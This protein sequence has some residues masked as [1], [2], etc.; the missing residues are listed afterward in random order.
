[1]LR[2][3]VL[4]LL[5]ALAFPGLATAHHCHDGALTADQTVHH[6]HMDHRK[7]PRPVAPP[8]A[9]FAI[10]ISS[11]C[12]GCAPQVALPQIVGLPVP[13]APAP[14]ETRTGFYPHPFAARVVTP[15]P[16]ALS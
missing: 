16:R 8:E 11:P 7:S 3:L 6:Q 14:T 5:L 13:V 4:L 15:P 2:R 9:P 12:L 1:M 10:A